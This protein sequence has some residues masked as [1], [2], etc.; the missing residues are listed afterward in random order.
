MFY[1][2]ELGLNTKET[3]QN[4]CCEEGE[5]AIDHSTVTR[6]FKNICSGYKTLDD[7]AKSG[8]PKTVESKAMLQAIEA[9]PMSCTWR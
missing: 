4:V 9:N 5:G 8:R 7:Q 6:K 2:F 3:T 1:E